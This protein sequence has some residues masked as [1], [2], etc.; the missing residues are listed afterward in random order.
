MSR[1]VY[2]K[3]NRAQAGFTLFEV[4]AA[5]AILGV[6]VFVLLDAHHSALKLHQSMDEELAFRQLVETVIGRAELEVRAGHLTDSGDFGTRYPGYTWS[7]EAVP[8]GSDEVVLLYEITATVS[9]PEEQRQ[10][11]FFV[12]DTGVGSTTDSG[13]ATNQESVFR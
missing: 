1:S 5:L 10:M 13:S 2:T 4:L 12:F 8:S 3:A 9:G 7:Y 11:K 6:A